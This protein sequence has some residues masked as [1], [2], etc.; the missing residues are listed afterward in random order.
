MCAFLNRPRRAAPLGMLLAAALFAADR[1]AQAAVVTRDV[2]VTLDAS[3]I[4]TFDL[5]LNL[6]GTNDFTFTAAFVPDPFFNVG[7]DTIDVERGNSFVIDGPT[8]DGFPTVSRLEQGETVLTVSDENLFSQ[9]NDQGNLA[10]LLGSDLSGNFE[11]QT[12]FV[13][14][15]VNLGTSQMPSFLF[16][17]AEVTVAAL[18]SSDGPLDLTIGRVGFNNVAGAAAPIP[19]VA[20]AVPEPASLLLFGLTGAGLFAGRRRMRAA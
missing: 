15:R 10:F 18:N 17:F 20:S 2:G 13:G 12:G 5:D 4:E 19:T 14:L 11:G 7:F 3:D 1:P 16:G 8:F 9:S 6:D